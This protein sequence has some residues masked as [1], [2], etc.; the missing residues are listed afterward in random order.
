MPSSSP[1]KEHSA[2][3]LFCIENVFEQKTIDSKLASSMKNAMILVRYKCVQPNT[4]YGYK[5]YIYAWYTKNDTGSMTQKAP[6]LLRM[7]IMAD[8]IGLTKLL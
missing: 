3:V 6:N 2:M 7:I 8:I 1:Q 4:V 5:V